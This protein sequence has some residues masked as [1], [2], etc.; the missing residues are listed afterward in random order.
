VLIKVNP[1]SLAG[2]ASR[3]GKCRGLHGKEGVRGRVPASALLRLAR[4]GSGS[5]I[6]GPSSG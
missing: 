1:A 4:V 3:R 5:A 2:L 6:E